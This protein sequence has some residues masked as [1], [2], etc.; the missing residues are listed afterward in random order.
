MIIPEKPGES[1]PEVPS[2]YYC[3]ICRIN[4][5]DPYVIFILLVLIIFFFEE[6]SISYYEIYRIPEKMNLFV[7]QNYGLLLL[8]F[9]YE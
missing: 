2:L 3:E 4:R 1:T 6:M 9:V 7:F 5:A 8:I